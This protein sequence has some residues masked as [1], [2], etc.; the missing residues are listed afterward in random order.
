MAEIDRDVERGHLPAAEAAAARAETA[1][2]LIAASS[3]DTARANPKVGGRKT[4]AAAILAALTVPAIALGVYFQLGSPNLPDAPLA[5]RATG[6]GGDNEIEAAVAHVE[7]EAAASPDNLKAWSAL[8]PVYVRL[9]RYNDAVNAWK[10]VLRLKGEDAEARAALGEAQVAA[11]DGVVTAEARASIDQAL[12][13]SPDLPMARF[14][15]GLAAEQ[16]GDKTK[17]IAIYRSVLDQVG[18]RP[19]WQEVVR[20]KLSALA[21]EPRDAQASASK[22]AGE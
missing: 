20:G 13:N 6:P 3:A 11:A 19:Y 18:D 21:G 9:G 16:D 10:Q 7:A 4:R 12:A 14:Y 2:R 8:A 22:D 5:S 1:R 15:L 17:A